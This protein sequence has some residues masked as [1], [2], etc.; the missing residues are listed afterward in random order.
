MPSIHLA[1]DIAAR[2]TLTMKFLLALLLT[3]N[4]LTCPVR[5]C[6]YETDTA[7]VELGGQSVCSCCPRTDDG[8]HSQTPEPR[9][10]K[11]RCMD[12]ICEGA[13]VETEAECLDS[14]SRSV[15]CFD[16]A[17]PAD[18]FVDPFREASRA[19]SRRPDRSFG[20]LLRGRDVRVAHQSWLI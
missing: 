18:H 19:F 6:S 14:L 9:G 10:Q 17:L 12:C 8:E 15:K 4:L 2:Y 7:D 5:C 1:R 16:P 3:C 11:C 20:R 13:V